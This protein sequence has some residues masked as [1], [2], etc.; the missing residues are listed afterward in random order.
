MGKLIYSLNVSLDGYAATSDGGLEWAEVDEE[1]HT[2]FNDQAKELAASLYGRRMYELMNGYWPTAED[3]PSASAPEREFSRIWKAIPR[4]VFSSTLESVDENSRL[5]SGDVGEQLTRLRQQYDGDMD[6]GGPTLAAAFIR[7]GLVD[8]FRLLV[9]PVIL[10][11]GLP[12]FPQLDEPIPLR[13]V[14]RHE[15]RSG[16]TYLG[17]ARV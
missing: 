12:F 9:H 16:V 5:V 17:F 7:R 14:E 13:Q 3:D 2:W 1:L 4:I 6:V 15:F 10:G 8:E 11:G